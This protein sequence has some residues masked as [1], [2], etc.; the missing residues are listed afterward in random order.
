MPAS[1]EMTPEVRRV[2]YN[3][4]VH[5]AQLSSI[6]LEAVQFKCAPD[7]MGRNKNLL[8]RELV[9]KKEIIASGMKEGNCVARISWTALGKY[10]KK[11]VVRCVASYLVSYRGMAGFPE[12]IIS[13]FVETI[14]RASTYPYFRAI[15]AQFDWS[16]NLG[17]LPLPILEFRADV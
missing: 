17:S 11:T 3:R 2:T 8:S 7:A 1:G 4:L 15:Y 6:V 9:G 12:A 14:G 5:E 16:A 13:E 10:K